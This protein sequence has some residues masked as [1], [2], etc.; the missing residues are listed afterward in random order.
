MKK[1]LIHILLPALFL[2]SCGKSEPANE[3]DYKTTISNLVVKINNIDQLIEAGNYS[4][5]NAYFL[6]PADDEF[7]NGLTAAAAD[8][9]TEF[10]ITN[11]NNNSSSNPSTGIIILNGVAEFL[12]HKTPNV[13]YLIDIKFTLKASSNYDNANSYKIFSIDQSNVR[14][15]NV[16]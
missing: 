14:S 10:S 2:L 4:A 6:N 1:S 9:D 8:T 16:N 3:T 13:K 5:L 12:V 11:L 7:L 15:V